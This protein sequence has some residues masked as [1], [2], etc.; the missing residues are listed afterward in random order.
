MIKRVILLSIFVLLYYGFSTILDL[1]DEK[2]PK[3]HQKV[4]EYQS[5]LEDEIVDENEA[6]FVV[7]QFDDNRRD[8]VLEDTTNEEKLYW[9]IEEISNEEKVTPLQKQSYLSSVKSYENDEMKDLK[10]TKFTVFLAY[11]VLNILIIIVIFY[12]RGMRKLK[13]MERQHNDLP[14]E[15]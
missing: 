1:Q 3:I 5:I 2:K 11:V 6:K 10:L 12:K 13:E 15:Q 4:S 7:K 8:N 9:Y 14:V